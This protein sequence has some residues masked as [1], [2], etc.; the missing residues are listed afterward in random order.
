[1]ATSDFGEL[2]KQLIKKEGLSQ[3]DF[4][5]RV[6]IGKPYFYDIVSG[7]VAPPPPE[8]QHRMISILTNQL[9]MKRTDFLILPLRKETRSLRI[10][11]SL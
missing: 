8:V 11:P 6:G 3:Q 2:L 9:L 1:M 5:T 10:L 4:H 7:K